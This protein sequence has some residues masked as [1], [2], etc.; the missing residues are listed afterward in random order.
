MA[1]IEKISIL[2]VPVSDQEKAKAF[3]TDVLGFEIRTEA[4]MSE[5]AKWIELAPAGADTSIS[6]VTWFEWLKPGSIGGNVLRVD[7][8]HAVHAD[9]T[10][11]GVELSPVDQQPWGKFSSFKDLD[12]NGWILMAD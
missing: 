4:P 7:D 8:I 11:K 5:T 9:L 3:Y 1:R 12:G 10:A 6:L 2:S